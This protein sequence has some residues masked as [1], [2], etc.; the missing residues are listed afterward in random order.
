VLREQMLPASN[1]FCYGQVESPYG[2]GQFLKDLKDHFTE[3]E[4]N[5]VTSEIKG[6]EAI[7]DSIQTFLGKGK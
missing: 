6:R 2:S 1:I 7:V 4:D 5:L 3:G